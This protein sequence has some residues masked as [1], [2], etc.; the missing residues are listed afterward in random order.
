MKKALVAGVT[1]Q[2]GA[3]LTELPFEKG[4][5]IH[6]IIRRASTFKTMRIDRLHKDPILDG[7]R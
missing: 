7:V 6:C 2:N 1:G 5:E 3:Y 4:Y